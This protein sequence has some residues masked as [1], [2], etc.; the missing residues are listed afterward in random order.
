VGEQSLGGRRR[1]RGFRCSVGEHILIS[2]EGK[3]MN[4]DDQRP[5]VYEYCP[6]CKL[7]QAEIID[8]EIRIAHI[9]RKGGRRNE[10]ISVDEARFIRGIGFGSCL[11]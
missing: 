10:R 3:N 2:F 9:C 11:A 8:G 7:R 1:S 6:N 5:V 4:S